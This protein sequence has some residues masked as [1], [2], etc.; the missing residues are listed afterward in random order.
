MDEQFTRD[1]AE[2]FTRPWSQR[3][4]IES[5]DR[6]AEVVLVKVPLDRLS[7]VLAEVAIESQRNVI[8][9]EIEVSGAFVFAYQL[10]GHPWSIMVSGLLDAPSIL[11]SSELAQLSKQLGQ[12][13]IRL[14]VSDTA[15]EIGYDLFEGGELVE[16]FRG[17]DG[18]LTDNSHEYEIQSQLYLLFPYPDDV[19]E[20]DDSEAQQT[21]YFWSRRRQITAEDIS[22]VWD[23]PHQL[24]R[25]RDAFDPAIDS[26]YLLGEDF[27]NSGRYRV[28]NLGFTLVL[29]YEEN[30][31]SQ[32]ITSIPDLARVDYF[33]F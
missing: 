10:V 15:C 25:D 21:A 12:P 18:E 22:N 9:A 26:N 11:Q 16:Y 8:G 4:G 2:H 17:S 6:N 31:H 28:Q 24:M 27:P 20:D 29:G 19:E 30:G 5:I 33:R 3:R 7:D 13:V 1:I 32:E 23:F 14:L